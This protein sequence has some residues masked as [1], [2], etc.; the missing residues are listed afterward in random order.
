MA[1]KFNEIYRYFL[2]Q[3]DDHDLASLGKEDLDYVME[4]YLM[5]SLLHVQETMTDIMD[6]DVE[7]Q[8]FNSDLHLAEKLLVAKAMKLTWMSE[9]KYAEDLMRKSIGDR[10]YKAIQGTD[11]LKELTN[12]EIELR[13]ELR[14]D[15]MRHAYSARDNWGDILNG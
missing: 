10:D 2:A 4:G 14:E 7:K 13:K 8:I 9:K 5:N 11:Y 15:L 3:V 1:T 12:A 6:V